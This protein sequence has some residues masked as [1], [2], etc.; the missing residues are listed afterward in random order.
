MEDYEITGDIDNHKELLFP[1]YQ[2]GDAILVPGTDTRAL[3]GSNPLIK[4]ETG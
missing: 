1:P 3:L 2:E 4:V